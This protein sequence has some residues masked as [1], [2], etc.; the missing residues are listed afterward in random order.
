M[1]DTNL[2][3]SFR[4]AKRAVRGMMRARRAGSSSSPPS[5]ACSARRAR[6]TTR[7]R[8]PAWSAWLGPSPASW[9]AGHHG[10]RR[11][12]RLRG[13]RHDGGAH[14]SSAA[15]RSTPGAARPLRND[16]RDRRGG[17]LAGIGR[18]GLHHRGR[19]PG[20]RRTRN[21]A[22]NG[23]PRRQADPG[24][25]RHD[26]LPR[27]ASRWPGS[28]R[29]KARPCCLPTS[30]ARSGSPNGRQAAARPTAG[31]RARRAPTTSTS[32]RSPTRSAST[33]TASTAWCTPSPTATRETLLGGKFLDGPWGTSPRRCRSRRTR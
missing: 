8:R 17:H 19:D 26:G 15:P 4:L 13:D 20:R 11:C 29:S 3:G 18:R 33:S 1:I 9:V 21:G 28:P 27:S 32:P 30:A 23:H 24:R 10:Q 12:A 2:T 7:P 5:S 14:P 6:S 16:R 25:R 22:L 31:A